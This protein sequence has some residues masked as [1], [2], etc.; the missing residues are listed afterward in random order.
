VRALEEDNTFPFREGSIKFLSSNNIVV[1][2]SGQEK[3][4][5]L[6]KM[7]NPCEV[8]NQRSNIQQTTGFTRHHHVIWTNLQRRYRY[9]LCMSIPVS[10]LQ[11]L[12]FQVEYLSKR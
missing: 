8:T 12:Q 6:I 4:M 5:Q 11:L 10:H 3:I 2:A 7:R 9:L 1:T